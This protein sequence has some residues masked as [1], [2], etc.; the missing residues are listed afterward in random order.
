MSWNTAW[1]YAK[2]VAAKK[3]IESAQKATRKD[4]GLPLG[5]RI[6]GLLTLQK[7]PFVRAMAGGSLIAIPK[8]TSRIIVSIGHVRLDLDGNLYRYYLAGDTDR[9]AGEF[10]QVYVTA[11]GAVAEV[12]YC[13]GLTRLYPESAEEQEAFMGESGVGLGQT[14]YTLDRQQMVD[15][16]IADITIS[17][18]FGENDALEYQRDAGN[19]ADEFVSPFRGSETRI[20]D[21]QG[22]DGMAQDICFMPYVRNLGDTKEYLLVSTNI[23]SSQNGDATKR[24]FNVDFMIGIPVDLDR[25]MIQ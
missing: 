18:A 19:P 16:G 7:T 1:Q 13:S 5:A 20:N 23:V 15:L 21:A 22:I 2:G 17:E 6:G 25:V 12:M 8:E 10:L 3:G 4:D 9:V 11:D 24:G 14:F